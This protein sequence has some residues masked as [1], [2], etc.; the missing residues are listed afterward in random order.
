MGKF[1]L[2]PGQLSLNQHDL[3]PIDATG[4]WHVLSYNDSQWLHALPEKSI[5]CAKKL[6]FGFIPESL[7]EIIYAPRKIDNNYG[8]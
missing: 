2:W 8:T 3:E 4:S 7:Q 1:R 5:S 6:L